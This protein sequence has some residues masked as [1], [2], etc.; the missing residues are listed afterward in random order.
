MEN[1]EKKA[2]DAGDA[3]K[4]VELNRQAEEAAKEAATGM[5]E[6]AQKTRKA[7]EETRQFKKVSDSARIHLADGR[8]FDWDGNLIEEAINDTVKLE[9]THTR[10]AETTEKV[11][12]SMREMGKE[13]RQV[14]DAIRGIGEGAG[15]EVE[16]QITPL[17]NMLNFIKQSFKDIPIMFG[18]IASKSTASTRQM[19]TEW[20]NLSD[21]A[22][23]YKGVMEGLG[24][25][26]LGF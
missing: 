4:E 8:T 26:G 24:R 1:V 9:N 13:T 17:R 14:N 2:D 3:L 15:D 5:D 12:Q 7:A 20:D 10:L 25:K 18:G 23:H 6:L 22:A 21:K 11:E 16:Q 19:E